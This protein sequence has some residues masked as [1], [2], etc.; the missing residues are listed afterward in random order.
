LD[1][2]K[3]EKPRVS[4]GFFIGWPVYRLKTRLIRL[5]F[6]SHEPLLHQQHL[7]RPLDATVEP[8][9][10]VGGKSGVF[11]WQNAPLIGDE[12]PEQIDILEFQSIHGE[13]NLWLGPRSAFFHR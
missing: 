12:L 10:V 1:I 5:S 2:H 8:P 11:A 7:S 4:R 3:E 13:I 6:E 9:L